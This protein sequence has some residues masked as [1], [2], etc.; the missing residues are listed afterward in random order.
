MLISEIISNAFLIYCLTLIQLFTDLSKLFIN[1]FPS[2]R[3]ININLLIQKDLCFVIFMNWKF[4]M[5]M[6]NSIFEYF[7]YCFWK[8]LQYHVEHLLWEIILRGIFRLTFG[9]THL[10]HD[11]DQDLKNKSLILTFKV[12]E[13]FLKDLWYIC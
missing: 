1:V 5:N 7:C 12:F 6:L 3:M 13:L 4:L 9:W 11:L 2:F 10:I 8:Y